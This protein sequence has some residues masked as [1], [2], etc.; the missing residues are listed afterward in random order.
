MNKFIKLALGAAVAAA[1]STSALAMDK[2]R[3]GTTPES[4]PPFTQIEADGSVA[5][6]E[7]DIADALCAKMEVECEWVLQAW[8][9]IIPALQANKFDAIIASMSITEKRKEV[10]DF[11]NKY[12]NTP[13]MFVGPKD[14]D[15]TISAEG[16]AGLTVGVQT[17]TTHAEYMKQK[18]PDV[19]TKTYDT[20][21][22][23]N[24]DLIA[25]RV[26]LLLADS[27]ALT[28]GLLTAEGGDAFEVKGEPFTDPVMGDG[29]GVGVRKGED[30]L[31]EKFN[32]AI[33]AIR[34][35]GTYKKI[36]DKYFGFDAFGS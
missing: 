14:K 19:R 30:E 28:D 20:Q 17:A 36:N 33:E 13:A 6:F 8:D 31:R 29:V 15:V 35:D 21:E 2:V 1:F 16:L 12:Y 26:D 18:L 3:I 10:I 11:S 24:L 27:I 25:G 23:A 9:G 7:A 34:A 4:Y 5:G 32:A 22:N